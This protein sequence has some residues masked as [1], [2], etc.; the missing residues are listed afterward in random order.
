MN[1]QKLRH[2]L[3]KLRALVD[4][5]LKSVILGVS[6]VTGV[7]IYAWSTRY[8]KTERFSCA[9]GHWTGLVVKQY[10]SSPPQ[11][12]AE[13]SMPVLNSFEEKLAKAK[14][15]LWAS[16]DIVKTAPVNSLS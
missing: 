3:N 16:W 11:P 8:S 9:F 12:E 4:K 6:I 2:F 15:N 7:S 14:P 10:S 13:P 1:N 5:N